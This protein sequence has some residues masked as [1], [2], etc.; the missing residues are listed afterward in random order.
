[1]FHD[2]SEEN[3]FCLTTRV[4]DVQLAELERAWPVL[5]NASSV[6]LADK[7]EELERLDRSCDR[8]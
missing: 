4:A 2:D 8:Y 1:M 5:N 3:R 7:L 6:A